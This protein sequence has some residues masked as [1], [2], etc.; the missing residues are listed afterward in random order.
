MLQGLQMDID[1]ILEVEADIQFARMQSN[2]LTRKDEMLCGWVRFPWPAIYGQGLWL[3]KFLVHPTAWLL[4]LQFSMEINMEVS[5]S[6]S[7]F[8]F[9]QQ[10]F[11]SLF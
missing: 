6:T 8:H 7:Q 4:C 5:K 9:I 1:R 2:V 3:I 10:D 11:F